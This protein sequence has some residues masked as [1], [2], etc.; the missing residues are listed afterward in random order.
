MC[1]CTSKVMGAER[2][3]WGIGFTC[4]VSPRWPRLS[5]SWVERMRQMW[6]PG[7]T[8]LRSDSLIAAD[9]DFSDFLRFPQVNK[10]Y[11]WTTELH[12]QRQPSTRQSEISSNI[13]KYDFQDDHNT[14]SQTVCWGVTRRKLKTA[15]TTSGALS[16]FKTAPTNMNNIWTTM[17]RLKKIWQALN[18]PK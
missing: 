11:P 18:K 3:H 17:K 9:F 7:L 2:R 1:T 16:W 5:T 10:K 14:F 15:T 13:F 8:R 6:Q 4:T 12:F